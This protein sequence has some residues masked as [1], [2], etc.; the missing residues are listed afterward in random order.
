M[1]SHIHTHI[2]TYTHIHIH[3]H[4]HT[5]TNIH[6]M[7][8]THTHIHTQ[9]INGLFLYVRHT[10]TH[11]GISHKHSHIQRKTHLPVPASNIRPNTPQYTNTHITTATQIS[12]IN[13]YD[14][15]LHIIWHTTTSRNNTYRHKYDTHPSLI[16]L[17]TLKYNMFIYKTVRQCIQ[18]IQSPKTL[19]S[20]TQPGIYPG[21]TEID[22]NNPKYFYTKIR[23]NISVFNKFNIFSQHIIIT[24]LFCPFVVF[25]TKQKKL[26]IAFFFFWFSILFFCWKSDFGAEWVVVHATVGF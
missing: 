8:Y 4:T 19:W 25:K 2:H 1:H 16:I 15:Y 24:I 3:T 12:H 6:T 26:K 14:L 11:I 18:H 17:Y 21:I 10:Q 9:I 23:N 7:S 22:E 20:S 13:I 5:Y